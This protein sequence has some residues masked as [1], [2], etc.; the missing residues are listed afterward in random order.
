MFMLQRTSLFKSSYY[1][2]GRTFGL[3]MSRHFSTAPQDV[4]HDDNDDVTPCTSSGK[5]RYEKQVLTSVA[6]LVTLLILSV[7]MIIF[8]QLFSFVSALAHS[9]DDDVTRAVYECILSQCPRNAQVIFG[10]KK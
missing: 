6:F 10:K 8:E 3:G 5:A 4:S 9:C 2:E 7:L 1:H